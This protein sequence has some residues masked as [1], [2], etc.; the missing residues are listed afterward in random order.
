MSET[1]FVPAQD[2]FRTVEKARKF[3][4]EVHLVFVLY[5]IH[6]I[7]ILNLNVFNLDIRSEPLRI[8]NGKT[9]LPVRVF[10][11]PN[12]SDQISRRKTLK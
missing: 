7:T 10:S 3:Q 12:G 6:T 8:G 9:S 4:P 2:P 1:G 5:Q 11:F